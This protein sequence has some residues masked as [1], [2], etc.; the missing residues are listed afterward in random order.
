MGPP[1]S[2]KSTV[3]KY[4][5]KELGISL[6][7]TD[8]IIEEREGRSISEIFLTDGEEGFRAIEKKVVLESLDVDD[9]I[10]ALGGGSVL[11]SDVQARLT[12]CPEVI[13]LDV[14]ISNA[15]PRVGFNKERPL[16]MGNPR[17]QWL[18]LMEKRRSIY[19]SLATR[20]VSTD[21]RK[22]HEV[23]HEIAQGVRQ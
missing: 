9:S 4:L 19:E 22:A 20:T 10:V 18:Q 15:A 7:D 1:G 21:N 11:D 6:I 8:R 3:G 5:A 13:F 23:A 2:G 16:L 12:Q 17:Q 14:S